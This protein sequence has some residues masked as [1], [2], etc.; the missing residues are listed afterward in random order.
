MKTVC[1]VCGFDCEVDA[2][3]GNWSEIGVHVDMLESAHEYDR[4]QEM[5]GQTE[6]V[7]CQCCLLKSMGFKEKEE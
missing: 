2:K 1:D 6:F 7:L 3:T 5:F 4:V